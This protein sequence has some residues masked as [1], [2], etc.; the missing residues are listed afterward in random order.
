MAKPYIDCGFGGGFTREPAKRFV[1]T[2]T[3][4][5]VIEEHEELLLQAIE[6]ACEKQGCDYQEVRRIHVYE[7]VM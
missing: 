1:I 6:K 5:T 4:G 7:T 2:F 3:D